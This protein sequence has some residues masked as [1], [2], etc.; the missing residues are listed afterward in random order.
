MNGRHCLDKSRGIFYVGGEPPPIQSKLGEMFA[1]RFIGGIPR[2]QTA[3]LCI[4]AALRGIA[5]HPVLQGTLVAQMSGTLQK[6]RVLR[7]MVTP[8]GFEPATP[9]LGIWCSI[10]LSYG[11]PGMKF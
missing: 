1:P 3:H 2:K 11:R 8:A 4:N 10:L 9:R 5:R 7:E 6:F